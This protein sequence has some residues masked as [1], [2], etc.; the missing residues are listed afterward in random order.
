M[1]RA[2]QSVKTGFSRL[3]EANLTVNLAKCDFAKATVVYLGE[4]VGGG[5][6][7][8]V[9]AKIEAITSFPVP[10]THLELQR[11]LGMAGYYRSFY[12][13]FYRSPLSDLLSPKIVFKWSPECQHAFESLKALPMHAP[14]LAAP[15]NDRAFKLAIDASDV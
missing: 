9:N 11:L 10:S 14:V 15:M 4:I 7:K 13:I 2:Y 8:P 12:R 6:V 3:T 1:G 5:M